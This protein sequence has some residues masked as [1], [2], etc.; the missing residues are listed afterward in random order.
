AVVIGTVI[1]SGVFK[2]PQAVAQQVPEF[3]PAMLVWVL[4]GVLA[5]L[6][7]LVLAEVSVLFPRAGGNYVF[8]REG[9]G[10][11]FGFLYGWVEFWIVRTASIAALATIFAE[12]L[13]ELVLPPDQVVRFWPRQAITVT[14]ILALAAVNARGVQW[15]GF[16]QL[17]I[18]V[19]KVGSLVAIALLPFFASSLAE[20][21]PVSAA[22]EPRPW[23]LSNFG[24]ALVGVIWAYHGWM[25]GALIAG[26]VARPQRN[27]PIAFLAGVGTV[28]ALYLG[29]NLA[30]HAVMTSDEMARLP[31]GTSVLA[32]F[33]RRLLGPWGGA[34]AAA[35]LMLS[36]FGALNGNVLVGPRL[37]FA[38][39]ED[40]LAPAAL[41][42]V[43]PRYHTPAL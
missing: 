3:G 5:T 21:R 1:G 30:Y 16:L 4:G 38:M 35:A 41:S 22:A 32:E 27:L 40:R 2:K 26:E 7:A 36:V 15:G 17:A 11:P 18:T 9:Y 28:M 6:G 37:L 23:N 8:L 29:A 33:G 14:V 20:P 34:A 39:G 25:N 10:R 13:C 42:R 24:A 12:S 19:V 31:E 43:H